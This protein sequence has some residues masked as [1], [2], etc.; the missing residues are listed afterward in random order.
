[1]AA[2]FRHF[3]TRLNA[4][5]KRL[6]DASDGVT[7]VEFAFVGPIVI[8]LIF[9][10]LQVAVIFLAK[11]T[12]ESATESAS[13]LVLTNQEPTTA[14]AFKTELCN[15]VP[16]LFTCSGLMVDLSPAV[17]YTSINTSPP[18]LTYNGSGAIT[19]SWNYLPPTC[20]TANPAPPPMILKVMYQWPVFV[21]PL[22]LVFSDLQGGKLF[23]MSTSVFKAEPC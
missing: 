18:R 10:A 2:R 16:A 12:L 8:A 17:S 20:P 13:R 23:M 21:G 3:A 22:G 7:A 14:A 4:A 9:G 15:D 6:A 1:M 19:N 5:L 11:A